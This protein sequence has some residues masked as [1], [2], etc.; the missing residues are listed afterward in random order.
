MLFFTTSISSTVLT[1]SISISFNA[2]T[3]EMPVDAG[4]P[5]I[6]K[7]DLTRLLL[8]ACELGTTLTASFLVVRF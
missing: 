7:E 6:E 2:F 8:Q 1:I 5:E 4:D 3:A